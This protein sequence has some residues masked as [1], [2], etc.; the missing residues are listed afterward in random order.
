MVQ[1]LNPF[2]VDTKPPQPKETKQKRKGKNTVKQEEALL[3]ISL[4]LF[5]SP[6]QLSIK[7]HDPNK[8]PTSSLLEFLLRW[9]FRIS[10]PL[11]PPIHNH[12][13]SS[14]TTPHQSLLSA[15]EALSAPLYTQ[16]LLATLRR[17]NL[18]DDAPPQLHRITDR[19]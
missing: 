9:H 12:Q 19:P 6:Q 4:C 3:Q 11:L 7:K 16:Q 17:P 8:N 18:S 14:T 15:I 2:T 1:A 10:P 13:H 5:I